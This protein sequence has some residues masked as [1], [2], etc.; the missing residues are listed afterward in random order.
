MTR[1]LYLLKSLATICYLDDKPNSILANYT[2]D[3]PSDKAL[4]K[5]Y[6]FA[7]FNKG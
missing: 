6:S 7:R 1:I 3:W 4:F 2:Q 5:N